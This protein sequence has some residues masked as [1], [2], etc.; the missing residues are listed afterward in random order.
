MTTSGPRIDGLRDLVEIGRGGAG[1][2]YKGW[3]EAHDRW[4]AAKILTGAAYDAR[5]FRRFERE[6]QALGR[7]SNHPGIVTILR[8]DV[9]DEGIPYLVMPFVEGG[10][11]DELDGPMPVTE[12]VRLGRAMTDAL[13]AAH[14][15][16]VLH[17]DLKPANVMRDG[18]GNY[19]ITDFGIA[20][21]FEDADQH[22]SQ[23]AAFTPAYASPEIIRGASP[24]TATDV[25][26]LGATIYGVLTAKVPHD[27]LPDEDTLQFYRRVVEDPVDPIE[28]ETRPEL[29]AMI[30]ATLSIEPTAR[31]T[32]EQLSLVLARE[33]QPAAPSG[34]ISAET[35]LVKPLT[36]QEP[37][38]GGAEIGTALPSVPPVT[39]GEQVNEA[40]AKVVDDH[41]VYRSAGRDAAPPS[42]A[43]ARSSIRDNR[44]TDGWSQEDDHAVG[45]STSRPRPRRLLVGAAAFAGLA[46]VGGGAVAA[47]QFF[48][49]PELIEA[50]GSDE[51]DDVSTV[52]Q[53][54]TTTTQPATTTAAPTTTTTRPTTTTAAP[55]T[56]TTRP[57]TTTTRPTTATT[58]PTTVTTPDY[59][60]VFGSSYDFEEALLLGSYWGLGTCCLQAKEE[61]GRLIVDGDS[62]IIEAALAEMRATEG[63]GTIARSAYVN[64]GYG[65][66]DAELVAQNHGYSAVWIAKLHIGY[67]GA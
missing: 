66:E 12:A 24:T 4:V 29:A 45:A 35:V 42:V 41:T 49:G 37:P 9:T 5:G 6:R 46:A 14:A 43:D 17:L 64:S 19:L 23:T 28:I 31:P 55:T 1:I 8:S 26:G 62:S 39:P 34:P 20:R 10:S 32:L 21:I 13:T 50:T 33:E 59:I 15:V 60:A 22:H 7:A 47:A 11:L 52:T 48:S 53:G 25:Y 18:Y 40:A 57:T 54:P 36:S 30:N 44:P 16:N 2:V 63:I 3:E 56:A 58:R 67:F 38:S 27:R 65:F 51:L 61:G